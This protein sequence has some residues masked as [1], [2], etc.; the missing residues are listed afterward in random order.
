LS[1]L[2]LSSV[3]QG[4]SRPLDVAQPCHAGRRTDGLS[5][6][7]KIV[8]PPHFSACAAH[9]EPWAPSAAALKQ[10]NQAPPKF[11]R[12]GSPLTRMATGGNEAAIG[13]ASQL[14]RK[15]STMSNKQPTHRAYAVTKN[16]GKSYWREIGAAWAHEDGKGFSL[17]LDYLP[18]DPNAELV[19]REPLPKAEEAEPAEETTA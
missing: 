4:A 7:G 18:L 17:K 15:E 12:C 5:L 1:R 6:N 13:A 10:K 2:I 8:V 11:Y 9:G 19:I 14:R 16:R 3:R